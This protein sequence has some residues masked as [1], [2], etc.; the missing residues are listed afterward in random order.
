MLELKFDNGNTVKYKI[1]EHTNIDMSIIIQKL[2]GLSQN[3]YHENIDL[4]N[5]SFDLD[6]ILDDLIEFK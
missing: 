1:K 5:A 6:K 3:M 2:F 4:I